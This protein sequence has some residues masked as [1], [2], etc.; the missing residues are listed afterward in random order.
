L[1]FISC[2]IVFFFFR[3]VVAAANEDKKILRKIKKQRKLFKTNLSIH[4][5]S[6]AKIECN[7]INRE[8]FFIFFFFQSIRKTLFKYWLYMSMRNALW[9]LRWASRISCATT[10]L[11]IA[12]ATNRRENYDVDGRG[13]RRDRK[14]INSSSRMPCSC[15]GMRRKRWRYRFPLLF[16]AKES[17]LDI[18][19]YFFPATHDAHYQI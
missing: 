1:K 14:E 12:S 2:K 13:N 8:D 3:Y 17:N 10:K 9:L 5:R 18:R 11:A 19:V 4:T 15:R 7:S 16:L 6:T